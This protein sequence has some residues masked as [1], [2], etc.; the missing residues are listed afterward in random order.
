MNPVPS[1]AAGDEDAGRRTGRS[2]NSFDDPVG[3]LRT[4]HVLQSVCQVLGVERIPDLDKLKGDRLLDGVTKIGRF[5][6]LYLGGSYLGEALV[7]GKTSVLEHLCRF[8]KLAACVADFHHPIWKRLAPTPEPWEDMSSRIEQL[9][10]R[11]G[12]RVRNL[13]L[14]IILAAA[15]LLEYEPCEWPPQAP[16][17]LLLD[18]SAFASLDGLELLYG[19]LL[20]AGQKGRPQ[21]QEHFRQV[22]RCAAR[23]LADRHAYHEEA[24][25]TW[26][27]VIETRLLCPSARE[28][29]TSDERHWQ[30]LLQRAELKASQRSPHASSDEVDRR[31]RRQMEISAR[32]QRWGEQMDELC[33]E[34]DN[35]LLAWAAE[36]AVLLAEH[37]EYAEWMAWF[38]DDGHPELFGLR[39][40]PAPTRPLLMPDHLFRR[41]WRAAPTHEGWLHFGDVL[42]YDYFDIRALER[43]HVRSGA[44]VD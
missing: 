13:H 18:A 39:P 32:R 4:W 15:G 37:A 31:R 34:R 12:L 33:V 22:L 5:R 20:H 30:A 35:P 10:P 24:H 21:Q 36:N 41:R 2:R 26:V 3:R 9:A 27:V 8:P 11:F 43:P 29:L 44:K 17:D 6:S 23:L 14:E 16:P 7:D 25:S 38:G 19:L 28:E 40:P 42:P 1:L